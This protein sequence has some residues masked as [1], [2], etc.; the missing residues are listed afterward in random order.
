MNIPICPNHRQSPSI[1][2]QSRLALL[3]ENEQSFLF[4]CSCCNLMWAVSKPQTKEKARYENQCRRVQHAT[5][6]ES[7]RARRKAYSFGRSN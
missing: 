4:T 7:D 2:E 5:E 6:V 3:G 1:C